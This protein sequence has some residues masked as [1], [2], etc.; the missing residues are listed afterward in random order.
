MMASLVSLNVGLP[1]PVAWSG[2]TVRTGVW[3]EPV[4]GRRQVRR[5]NVNGDG[6]GD[7]AGHGGE[8]RA[9]LVY[10]SDSYRH[11]EQHFGVDR[12]PAGAFGENFTV[13]GL[14]DDEVCIGDRYAIGQ[15]QFE[16]TQP[17]VTC[18]RVGMRLGQPQL[19]AL[20]V[21]HRRPGFYLR[22]L[23][24]GD[25]GAGDEITLLER[26]RHQLSVATVDALLYLPNPDPDLVELAAD[27]PALSPGWL[28]SFRDMLE[29]GPGARSPGGVPAGT[30]SAWPGFRRLVVHDVVHETALVSS[31][32]LVAADGTPLPP[33]RPGQYLTL[34]VAGAGDPAPVRS[35]SLSTVV[36]HRTDAGSAPAD[37]AT[38]RISIKRE[39]AGQ[40]SRY[41][42]DHLVRG[43]EVEV[44]APRGEF[45]LD[46]GN[47]PVVLM[48]A[49]IGATPVL[50]MLHELAAT[51][52]GREVWWIHATQTLETLAFA[53]EVDDL[54]AQLPAARSTIFLSDAEPPLPPR[55]RAG[56]LTADVIAAMGLPT[57]A[58]VY[59]CGPTPFMNQMT[60]GLVAA[61][62]EPSRIHT[63]RF[64]SVSSIHP[65]V[66]A[67]PTRPPHQPPGAAGTG[68]AVT[69][70][71]TGLTTRWS[72]AF[73]SVLELAEA[74]DVPTQ[75]S[76]RSG[77][78]HTCVTSVMSGT[79]DYT[80][81]PLEPPGPDEAL[82]CV[83]RPQDDMVLDL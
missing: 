5:L 54:L 68:P 64:G 56:R 63:E 67:A 83:G 73:A 27:I 79:V 29:A 50:G 59:L 42:H 20:L 6:Q 7:L 30:R 61:G 49:G 80:T 74:C 23:E 81:E 31:F 9:V 4:A 15:A 28:G 57:N 34:R 22:V 66:V 1:K 41:L 44:A 77:V 18:F 2:R 8:Q 48:S 65:G 37:G 53:Q 35:Y 39:S 16:V 33:V 11:W 17:R 43:G 3:K 72:D 21:A 36:P 14:P 52:S 71:R 69:F 78:C 45:V 51:R 10:Q 46:E 76:C 62:L 58:A 24:E 82:I 47:D 60:D 55:T 40:V 12:L 26:G 25:V 70:A 38:Y 19:P 32:Y 75:W 13:D